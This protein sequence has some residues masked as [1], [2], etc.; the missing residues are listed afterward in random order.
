MKY[1]LGILVEYKAFALDKSFYYTY[2]GELKPQIGM[3]VKIPFKTSFI[4]GFINEVKEVDNFH[5]YT[6]YELKSIIEIIDKS[7]IISKELYDLAKYM[8]YRYVAS[9]ISCLQIILPLKIRPSSSSL[10]ANESKKVK[11]VIFN[12]FPDENKKITEK[13]NEILNIIYNSP[14]KKIKKSEIKNLSTL[15]SLIKKNLITEI[16][17]T[18]KYSGIAEFFDFNFVLSEF[19]QRIFDDIL[20]SKNKKILLKGIT[21]SGKTEIYL[22]LID[23]AISKGKNVLYLVPEFNLT[24]FIESILYQKYKD[25]VS[26]INGF[27]L[28][29]K[30]YDEYLKISEN[31]IRIVFG[32]GLAVF[33]PLQNI[34][35]I[36][37]DEEFSDSYKNINQMPNYDA[38]EIAEHRSEIHNSIFLM[39]SSTPSIVRYAKA[40]KGIYNLLTLNERYFN[41]LNYPKCEIV[42]MSDK[43][44]ISLESVLFS[45]QLIN[46]L[47]LTISIRNKK[48]FILFNKKGYSTKLLCENCNAVL[49]CKKC[50]HD[51]IYL[52]QKDIYYCKHCGTNYKKDEVECASCGNKTFYEYSCGLEKIEERMKFIFPNYVIKSLDSTSNSTKKIVKIFKE[53]EENKIDILV[54]TSIIS[55]GHD[56]KNIG[57]VGI[58]GIDDYFSYKQYNSNEQI[59]NLITQTIGRSGREK[60]D[61]GY[62]IIQTINPKNSIILAAANQNYELFYEIELKNRLISKTPPY[63]YIYHISLRDVN[64]KRLN[65]NIG[66]VLKIILNK[67]SNQKSFY[68]YLTKPKYIMNKQFEKSLIIKTKLNKDMIDLLNLIK[69]KWS[70]LFSN[71]DLYIKVV[72]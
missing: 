48:A 45:K 25:Q 70:D 46:A 40:K 64:D 1:I 62:G 18:E 52:K 60:G 7:P 17:E 34:G 37:V 12:K 50:N 61:F 36:I 29:S 4:I 27:K 57:M 58:I 11:Y 14:N 59:F 66:E 9:L 23:E 10:N 5:F 53:F 67:F 54:G 44:N 32:T 43:N 51:L 33:A 39:G 55:K 65:E 31:K 21:G 28:D 13:Q 15:S 38:V 71:T 22:K 63:F 2:E 47:K 24:P 69:N 16:L 72:F 20:N 26:F 30:V 19:Q 41:N 6:P 3:R 42:N 68:Y 8:S 56:F 35:L 49:K